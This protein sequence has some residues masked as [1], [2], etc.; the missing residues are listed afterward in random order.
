MLSLFERNLKSIGFLIFPE[1]LLDQLLHDLQLVFVEFARD[2]VGTV[3][4][5]AEV[6]EF[7]AF[8]AE[9]EE[10]LI[11]QPFETDCFLADRAAGRSHFGLVDGVELEPDEEL[12]EDVPELPPLSP[13]LDDGGDPAL[14]LVSALAALLYESDR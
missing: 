8:R 4:P 6:D 14:E 11:T 3:D 2:R 5:A 10:R 12:V 9:R 1:L 7:A 13:D